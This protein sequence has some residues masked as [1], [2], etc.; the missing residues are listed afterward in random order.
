VGRTAT[1]PAF[2]CGPALV[3]AKSYSAFA[4]CNARDFVDSGMVVNVV[5]YPVAPG[6]SPAVLTEQ[7]FH[8]C[9]W[10]QI[11]G[12]DHRRP[13]EYEGPTGI[14]GNDPIV[15]EF[16]GIQFANANQAFQEWPWRAFSDLNIRQSAQLGAL[17]AWSSEFP[18]VR[19]T[20]STAEVISSCRDFVPSQDDVGEPEASCRP[21]PSTS[22]LR[23]PWRSARTAKPHPYVR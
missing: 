4:P 5:V 1:S 10:I 9:P 20:P 18:I 17:A 22:D 2:S 21:N 8:H 7:F 13:I 12:K 19:M 16:E 6:G 3:A 15:L 14:V 23:R 11:A